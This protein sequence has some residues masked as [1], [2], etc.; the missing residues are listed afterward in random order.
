MNKAEALQPPK[1][2]AVIGL[3]D[4]PMRPSHGV[5][6]YLLNHG[7]TIIPINPTIDSVFGLK[8]YPSL[9]SIPNPEEVDIVDV[10]RQP[11]AVMAIVDEI[12]SLNIHPLVW[13]QEGV[14]APEAKQKAEDF[15]LT[16]VMDECIKKEHQKLS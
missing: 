9:T 8:S 14:I 6:K 4:N 1:N 16:V 3:S 15:G 11:D 12:I 5:A 2:I 7:Y 10:F 13:L